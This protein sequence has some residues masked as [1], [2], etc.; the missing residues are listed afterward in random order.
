[1]ELN[2]GGD[3]N[4]NKKKIREMEFESPQ[5]QNKSPASHIYMTLKKLK[6]PDVSMKVVGG[7]L[8]RGEPKPQSW[9]PSLMNRV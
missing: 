8:H 1:M 3:F 4:N 5:P 6:F 9:S 2:Q 7:H